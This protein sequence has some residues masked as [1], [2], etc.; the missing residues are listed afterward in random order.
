MFAT[1][2]RTKLETKSHYKYKQK[3]AWSVLRILSR[4]CL[5]SQF[6]KKKLTSKP[7]SERTTT[8]KNQSNIDRSGHGILIRKSKEEKIISRNIGRRLFDAI[9]IWSSLRRSS[10]AIEYNNN[11]TVDTS[12][13][14]RDALSFV[15]TQNHILVYLER[16]RDKETRRE[17]IDNWYYLYAMTVLS[18][19]DLSFFS[20]IYAKENS[21]RV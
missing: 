4:S 18:S 16:I 3:D 2:L 8:N 9:S 1:T 21:Y 20:R 14:M 12:R 19:T 6:L 7:I 13:I 11:L 15:C 17:R 10:R 5:I